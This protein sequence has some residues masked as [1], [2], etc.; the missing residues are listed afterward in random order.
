MN[1]FF[2]LLFLAVGLLG[3]ETM[4]ST[5]TMDT[6]I[7]SFLH[8]G[9]NISLPVEIVEKRTSKRRGPLFG[10]RDVTF[11]YA[12]VVKSENGDKLFEFPCNK[13]SEIQDFIAE[14]R[15]KRSNDRKHF[16]VGIDDQTV[17]VF[18]FLNSSILLAIRKRKMLK[19]TYALSLQSI[20]MRS[21]NH[22]ICFVT[23]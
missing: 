2:F 1:K 16:A 8:A 15:V 19:H 11:E 21:T 22:E 20:L 18:T 9:K 23:M 6:E 13:E 3:C 17:A 4:T 5:S 7:F 14:L 10:G 12:F